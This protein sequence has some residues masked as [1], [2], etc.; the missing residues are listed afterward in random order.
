MIL[1][2]TFLDSKE[3]FFFK[4]LDIKEEYR[5]EDFNKLYCHQKGLLKNLDFKRLLQNPYISCPKIKD[6]PGRQ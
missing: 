3:W 6:K 5:I 4:G 1:A 2:C